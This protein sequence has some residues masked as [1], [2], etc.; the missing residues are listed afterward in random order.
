M[1]EL[2]LSML[3]ALLP[4]NVRIFGACQI[5]FPDYS[6]KLIDGPTAFPAAPWNAFV[7]RDPIYGTLTAIE[8]I[9]DGTGD[10]APEVTLTLSPASDA[11]ATQLAAASMQGSRT[12]FW[13]GVQD[14]V[15]GAVVPDPY[16]LADYRVDVPTL[17]WGQQAR[18]VEYT[19]VDVFDR[20]FDLE[21]GIR[22]SDAWHQ[23]IYAGELGLEYVTG[24]DQ[25]VYWGT[26]APKGA[27]SAGAG[28]GAQLLGPTR[29]YAA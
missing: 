29:S 10:S 14:R 24:I 5:D 1:G 19:L 15:T 3:A 26:D 28:A 8:A 17:K 2:S 13:L 6:L 20:L 11:A 7:A 25:A 9:S 12:R 23:G 21:E 27:V 22:L 4:P 18:S 16:L